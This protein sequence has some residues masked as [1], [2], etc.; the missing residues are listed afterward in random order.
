LAG[1]G[2]TDGVRV[3][4]KHGLLTNG[5]YLGVFWTAAIGGWILPGMMLLLSPMVAWYV[6]FNPVTPP[7]ASKSG[8][9]QDRSSPPPE[10]AFCIEK[11]STSEHLN[12]LI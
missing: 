4:N 2:Y 3:V 8:V 9:D 11:R 7:T 6:H 10:L 1:K 12:D 5:Q